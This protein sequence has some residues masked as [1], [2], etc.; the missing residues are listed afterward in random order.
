MLA[1]E[2]D[3]GHMPESCPR[4]VEALGVHAEGTNGA[5]PPKKTAKRGKRPASIAPSNFNGMP[6]LDL[7]GALCRSKGVCKA[8]RAPKHP[9]CNVVSRW[10]ISRG[11]A[12][13]L[14][15]RVCYIVMSLVYCLI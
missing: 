6:A 1:G 10:H 7:A 8:D 9:C 2:E 15:R 14:H 12:T 13:T 5:E 4:P 11:G 3:V